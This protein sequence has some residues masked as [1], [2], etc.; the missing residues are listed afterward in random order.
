M[1]VE[2][3][4]TSAS[5][6]P[7]ATAATAATIEASGLARTARAGSSAL[8]IETGASMTSTPSRTSPICAAGP[9]SSTRTPCSA[10]AAAAPRA[11]SAGP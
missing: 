5:A 1:P 9:N 8:A 4:E 7:S 3:P 2:P 10:T 6:R 11:T